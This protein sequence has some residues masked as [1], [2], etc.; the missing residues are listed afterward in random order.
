VEIWDTRHALEILSVVSDVFKDV[1]SDIPV[2]D[3]TEENKEYDFDEELLDE[4]NEFIKM[5]T[6]LR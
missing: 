2:S 6:Y 3:S 5:M 1:N 4:W